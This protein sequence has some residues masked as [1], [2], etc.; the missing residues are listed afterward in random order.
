[1]ITIEDKLD[2]FRK[3]LLE[4]VEKKGHEELAALKKRIGQEK[5]KIAKE[6]E[7]QKAQILEA[8]MKK[9][10][11]KKKQIVSEAQSESYFKV[12]KKKEEFIED[13][14]VELRE[15]CKKFIEQ[16]EYKD[17][18][19]RNISKAIEAIEPGSKLAIIMTEKDAKKY[20][21]AVKEYMEEKK[22]A[23]DVV[24][25]EAEEEIIGGFILEDRTRN[26]QI[27]Y[28]I[29]TMIKESRGLIGSIVGQKLDG[30][31]S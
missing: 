22:V 17:F 30:V 9:G 10:E 27:D 25:E 14:T 12:L 4:N 19:I 3:L 11:N 28:S 26:I 16:M 31:I 21:E 7:L 20:G 5:A 8:A 15:Y 23:D 1:L 13:V 29:V 24:I 18:I 6:T 2:M